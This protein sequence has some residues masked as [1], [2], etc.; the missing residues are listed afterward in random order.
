MQLR[1]EELCEI[2]FSAYNIVHNSPQ[3]RELLLQH[4]FMWSIILQTVV[5][6]GYRKSQL[7]ALMSID[8]VFER[9]NAE[10]LKQ[11]VI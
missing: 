9:T 6:T 1:D 10:T 11:F 2:N 8:L 5:A 7:E 4:Q 3:T